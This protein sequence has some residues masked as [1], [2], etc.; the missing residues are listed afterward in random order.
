MRVRKLLEEHKTRTGRLISNYRLLATLSS[1]LLLFPSSPLPF[2][3]LFIYILY[4]MALPATPNP[5]P[6]RG[7]LTWRPTK[8][9]NMRDLSKDD[10]F[11][12]HLL[13]EKLGTG[14]VPLLVHKMDPSRRLPKTD[15]RDLLAIVR[16]V[17][18]VLFPRL[19]RLTF[20]LTRHVGIFVNHTACRLKRTRP[21]C[22]PPGCRRPTHVCP[23]IAFITS[24]HANSLLD[25]L[26][27]IRYYLKSYTQKQINAFA[28]CVRTFS[29]HFS[30][31]NFYS[32]AMLRAT[33]SSII[34]LVSLKSLT[35]PVIPTAPAS[36]SS[37]FWPH[38]TSPLAPSSQN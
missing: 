33:S 17:S 26:P 28:T 10:D 24:L 12:S 1:P 23:A 36:L 38:A 11:L 31:L 7:A 9:M 16:R 37:V 25:S 4:P 14:T 6:S 19:S 29:S 8:I 5:Q 3:S 20:C 18:P 32:P 34:H 13:V 21:A 2:V 27:P 30:T 22:Y 35:R 15:A